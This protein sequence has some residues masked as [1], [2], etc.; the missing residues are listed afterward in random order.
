[1]RSPKLRRVKKSPT[2]SQ[3]SWKNHHRT[4]NFRTPPTRE[5]VFTGVIGHNGANSGPRTELVCC[6]SFSTAATLPVR[7]W[8]RQCLLAKIDAE[9]Y[10]QGCVFLPCLDPSGVNPLRLARASLFQP[11]TFSRRLI[12]LG[13]S[14]TLSV[15]PRCASSEL[16]K[17]ACSTHTQTGLAFP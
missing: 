1:M 17:H 2:L 15:T 12:S 6:F 5:L 3:H 9:V 7:W 8:F 10:T 14:A 13:L 11:L 16:S 4:A